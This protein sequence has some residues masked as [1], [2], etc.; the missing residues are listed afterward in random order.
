M[1]TRDK[2]GEMT[3]QKLSIYG[4]KITLFEQ[5]TQEH[6]AHIVL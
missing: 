6:R 3:N 5:R 2:F 1:Y 4:K